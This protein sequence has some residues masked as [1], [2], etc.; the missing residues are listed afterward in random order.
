MSR[1]VANAGAFYSYLANGL[2]ATPAVGGA[3]V[4][5]VVLQRPADRHLRPVRL[6]V[7][8]LHQFDDGAVAAVVGVGRRRAALR[9]PARRA[10]RRPERACARGAV[11]TGVHRGRALRHRRVRSSRHKRV[12]ARCCVPCL[13]RCSCQGWRRSSRSASPRSSASRQV[14]STARSAAT[15]GSRS[16]GQRSRSRFVGLFYAI[17]SW[18]ML[19]TVGPRTS[20]RSQ[21]RTWAWCSR[22]SRRTGAGPW[23]RSHACCSSP[24]PSPRS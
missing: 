24:A 9:R 4:A 22:G 12:D 10:P 21:R 19:V 18:A 3:F 1:Y 13:P 2:G 8:R 5:L 20:S 7:R 16:P 6:G 14:R 11:G 15:H 23:P 17:S